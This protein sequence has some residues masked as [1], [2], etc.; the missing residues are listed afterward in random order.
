MIRNWTKLFWINR[1]L[2]IKTKI[3]TI[4]TANT[5]TLF[6]IFNYPYKSTASH[7][8]LTIRIKSI[9]SDQT[10]NYRQVKPNTFTI[11][12]P[13]LLDYFM[14]S[15]WTPVKQFKQSAMA[16]PFL[17]ANGSLSHAPIHFLI[18]IVKLYVKTLNFVH[19]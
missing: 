3:S 18:K 19:P 4:I 10:V 17:S 6:Y 1:L 5:Q 11:R 13:K 7:L 2:I 14:Q 12:L 15:G 16:L 9:V 8:I